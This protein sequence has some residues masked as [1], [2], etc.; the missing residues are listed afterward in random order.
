MRIE[1]PDFDDVDAIADRWVELA[2]GQRAHGSRLAAD[3]NRTRAREAV[4]GHLATDGVLVARDDGGRLVG[5]VTYGLA[6]G[7]YES[8]ATQ[9]M[10]HN[11]WVAPERRG[12]GIG[13]ALLSRAEADLAERGAGVVALEVLADN[14][15]AR[16]FY[17][18]EGYREHRV[19][20]EKRVA[21]GS[22]NRGEEASE[23][24]DSSAVGSGESDTDSSGD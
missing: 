17:R 13:A 15:A 8:D 3:A 6:T 20:M 10:V 11:V 18:R 23:D 2:R 21:G 4:A 7:A 16:R 9:G 19:E 14:E 24:A 22:S 12:E 1:R 5:F